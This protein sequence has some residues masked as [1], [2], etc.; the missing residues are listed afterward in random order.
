MNIDYLHSDELEHELKIRGYPTD[1]T[2]ADKRKRLRPAVRMEK[3][4]VVFTKNISL[5]FDSEIGT[6]TD[7]VE[8]LKAAVDNFNFD[9][10]ANEYKRYR[11]RLLYIMGRINRL[12]DLDNDPRK[13]QLMV[14][15]GEISDFLEETVLLLEPIKVP[16][17]PSCIPTNMSAGTSPTP[18]NTGSSP[19]RSATQINQSSRSNN[20]SLIDVDPQ[21]LAGAIGDLQV[22]DTTRV[23]ITS[24]TQTISTSNAS[25]ASLIPT[26]RYSQPGFVAPATSAPETTQG[27]LPLSMQRFAP[28]SAPYQYPSTAFQ[29]QPAVQTQPAFP[30]QATYQFQPDAQQAQAMLKG[31]P[32]IAQRGGVSDFPVATGNPLGRVTFSGLPGDARQNMEST[33]GSGLEH[34]HDRLRIFKTVSQ[35]NVKFDGSASVRNFL[36]SVD[37]LRVACGISKMQLMG[38]AIVLFKGVALDWFR[39]NSCQS[40]TWDDLVTMLRVSFLPGEYEEDIWADIRA[41]TQG[42]YERSTT[43]ISVMQNLFNKL[44]ERPSEHTRLQIIR[45]NLLP[46][47][48]SQLALIDCYTISDLTVACQRV[49]DSQAHI[50]RF[51]PPPTNPTMVTERELMYNPRLYRHQVTALNTAASVNF[52]QEPSSANSDHV[53][54]PERPLNSR[55]RNMICWNC[56]QA[57]HI[58]RDCRQPRSKHCFGCGNPDVTKAT[59]PRC[60]GNGPM[61]R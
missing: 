32:Q 42:Q 30:T 21:D 11:S 19:Q 31:G 26:V 22:N 60:S 45:R 58:K 55:S 37:E 24:G 40:H 53:P 47:I 35:W 44:A 27:S 49:E 29:P 15:C 6:C 43:Y 10:A 17:F 36:E 7:K 18:A 9:N 13:G 54:S 57:G 28:Y 14:K 8:E 1:G 20:V 2:V 3:E 4:G 50:A 46:Y 51:R 23:V 41:R 12:L 39:A 5:D 61:A 33:M 59:C 38:V 56:R 48:Q 25:L 16:E 34:T 52:S